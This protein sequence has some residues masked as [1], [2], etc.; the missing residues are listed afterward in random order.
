MGLPEFS[1]SERK[2]KSLPLILTHANRALDKDGHRFYVGE[3]QGGTARCVTNQLAF[4][5]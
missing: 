5:V 2:D 3:G 4:I 1:T